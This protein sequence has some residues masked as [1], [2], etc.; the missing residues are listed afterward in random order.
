MA[1]TALAT[2]EPQF[3]PDVH[4]QLKQQVAINAALVAG[5]AL[6][7]AAT[8]TPVAPPPAKRQAV[9]TSWDELRVTLWDTRLKKRVSGSSYKGDL[10]SFLARNP[11]MEVYNRQ[12]EEPKPGQQLLAGQKM[13]KVESGGKTRVVMW[14]TA[15]KRKLTAAEC[16]LHSGR[17]RHRQW[18]HAAR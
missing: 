18:R 4:Q 5:A 11:H 14:H 6:A 12:D 15:E 7:G 16:W 17:K 10:S 13:H 1:A 2:A 8:A 9:T 3:A